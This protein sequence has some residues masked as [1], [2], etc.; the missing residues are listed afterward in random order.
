[1]RDTSPLFTQ[2]T[3]EEHY[4]A[5]YSTQS[6][7]IAVAAV[8][9]RKGNEA[10]SFTNFGTWIT[11]SAPGV[12]IYSTTYSSYAH[13]YGYGAKS[14]TSMACP[15]VAGVLALFLA[16]P[17]GASL[18]YAEVISCMKTSAIDISNTNDDGYQGMLG[19]GLIDAGSL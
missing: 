2:G 9:S 18:S 13:T 19:G 3:D 10:A 12:D 15:H 14:G 4:P 7:V 5:Y 1:M 11:I 8:D 17:F 6:D 16:T